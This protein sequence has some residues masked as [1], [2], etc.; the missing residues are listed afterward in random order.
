MI[1]LSQLQKD[2]KKIASKEKSA[3]NSKFFKTGEGEYGFGDVFW[4]L[5]VPQC[6]VLALKYKDLIFLDIATLLKSKYHEERLIAILILVDKF[7]K[8]PMEQ[9]RVR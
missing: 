7:E 4:G 3:A 2:I 6:R 5:T 8:E 1:S 9:R